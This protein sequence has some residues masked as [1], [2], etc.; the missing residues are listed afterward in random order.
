MVIKRNNKECICYIIQLDIKRYFEDLNMRI[1]IFG[2]AFDPPHLGHLG[3]LEKALALE[4][5][6]EI[7]LMPTFIPPLKM[8]N[9]DSS[10]AGPTDRLEMCR[11]LTEHLTQNTQHKKLRVLD[12]EIKRGGKSYTIDT[13]RKLKSQY[14]Q[15][16]FSFLIGS[17]W[18]KD[19]GK[20][21]KAEELF[22]EIEFISLPRTEISSSKIREKIKKGQSIKGLVPEEIEEYIKRHKLYV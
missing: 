5:F 9:S 19:L 6:E 11:I 15:N 12:L 3:L 8:N 14:S 16:Q 10:V 2:G 21:H 18:V 20:W 7:W 13:V 17:D 4:I 1:L 22:K